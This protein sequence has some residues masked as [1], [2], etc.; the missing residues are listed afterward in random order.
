LNDFVNGNKKAQ[1]PAG[2]FYIFDALVWLLSYL[3]IP[4]ILSCYSYL[5]HPALYVSIIRNW[6]RSVYGQSP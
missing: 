1:H 6:M 4:C 3:Y 2:L 5:E